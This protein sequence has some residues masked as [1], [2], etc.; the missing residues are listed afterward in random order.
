MFEIL[1]LRYNFLVKKKYKYFSVSLLLHGC[2]S[3]QSIFLSF[4][5]S[6]LFRLIIK[7]GSN[8]EHCF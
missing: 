7:T 4:L 1:L 3:H 6:S 2:Q 8:F 5:L